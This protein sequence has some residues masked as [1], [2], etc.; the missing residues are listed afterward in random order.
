MG[1]DLG[2]S[3]RY[4]KPQEK[5]VIEDY[6]KA[7]KNLTI[8]KNN[9]NLLEKEIDELREKNAIART[10]VSDTIRITRQQAADMINRSRRQLQR[11]V[12]RYREKGIK[13]LR[14]NSKKPCNILNKKSIDIERRIIQ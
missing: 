10:W 12:K 14:F 3:K 2:I 6:L 9:D 11:I 7:V 1:H 4:Y 8:Q 5:V 13:G